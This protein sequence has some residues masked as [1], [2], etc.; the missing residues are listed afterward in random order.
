MT[1]GHADI[2]DQRD[3][4]RA[5]FTG[6]LALHVG[7]VGALVVYA[8]IYGHRELIGDPNA[9]GA[10]VG[11]EAVKA[12]PLPHNGPENPVAHDSK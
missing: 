2:L 4:L 11:I 5:P 3:S 9:G 6:A 7:V 10:A 12:I 8:Y 1:P